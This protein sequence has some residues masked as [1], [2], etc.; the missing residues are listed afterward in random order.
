MLTKPE[1]IH[2]YLEAAFISID[3]LRNAKLNSRVATSGSTIS[4]ILAF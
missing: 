3:K 1:E 2:K 4:S